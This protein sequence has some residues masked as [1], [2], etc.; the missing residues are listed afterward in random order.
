MIRLPCRHR[1]LQLVVDFQDD[2]LGT[3]FAVGGLVLAP[4][5]G[6]GTHDVVDCVARSW[7][8]LGQCGQFGV[9]F[10]VHFLP[11]TVLVGGQIE[12]EEGRV[13]LASQEEAT[14]FVPAERWA[15]EA[16][17]LGERRKIPGG[18]GQFGYTGEEPRV[19]LSIGP[20]ASGI[21][22]VVPRRETWK[23]AF[24]TLLPDAS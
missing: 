19:D 22:N 18:V 12:V 9:V 13:Q 6:E 16:A 14:G 15:V 8:G 20:I 23:S 1:L 10:V 4:H 3:V 17:V 7:K 5:N 24:L 21:E 2:A 11:C